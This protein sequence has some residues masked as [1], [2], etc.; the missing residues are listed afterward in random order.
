MSVSFFVI[1]LLL[2]LII[3]ELLF[4]IIEVVKLNSEFHY[5]RP[6]VKVSESQ[7]GQ[8]PGTDVM[9]KLLAQILEQKAAGD[10]VSERETVSSNNQARQTKDESD[11]QE[12]NPVPEPRT[13]KPLP[14]QVRSQTSMNGDD[15]YD[16]EPRSFHSREEL[17]FQKMDDA[18]PAMNNTPAAVTVQVCPTCGKE[19]SL[20]RKNCFSC[21]TKLTGIA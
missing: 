6:T 7:R 21:E 9:Y 3:I 14:V 8:E 1:G 2:V 20:F 12:E 16:R 13:R 4:L 18:S 5:F 15:E 17:F 10:R 19:N 11:G